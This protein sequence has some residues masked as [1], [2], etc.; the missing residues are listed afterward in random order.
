MNIWLNRGRA[1][2]GCKIR[3]ALEDGHYVKL[4]GLYQYLHMAKVL[5]TVG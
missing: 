3:F 5:S 4:S 2:T 1:R